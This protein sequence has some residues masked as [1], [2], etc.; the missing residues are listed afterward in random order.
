M[1]AK[2]DLLAEKHFAE[3]VKDLAAIC[4]FE[5]VHFRPAQ[6]RRGHWQTPVEGTLGKGWVDWI[7]VH[8][9]RRRTLFRELKRDDKDLEPEQDRVILVLQAAGCDA[10]W[11]RPRDL[12]SG[13]IERELRS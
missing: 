12:D 10:G 13:R 5:Y 6:N 2:A 1:T 11:W 4:G 8:P 9:V 3:Q 7:F